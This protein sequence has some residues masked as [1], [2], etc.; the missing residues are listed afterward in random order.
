MWRFQLQALSEKKSF[1]L[2]LSTVSFI[3]HTLFLIIIF[4]SNRDHTVD[5]VKLNLHSAQV[6]F[7]PTFDTTKIAHSHKNHPKKTVQKKTSTS[8]LGSSKKT[9]G[10]AQLTGKTEHKKGI[11][12]TKVQE[13]S[14]TFLRKEQIHKQ[15]VS[16]KTSKNVQ[17]KETKSA[18]KVENT[19]DFLPEY[20]QKFSVA[21]MIPQFLQAFVSPKKDLSDKVNPEK[22]KSEKEKVKQSVVKKQ[23]EIVSAQLSQT[24]SVSSATENYNTSTEADSDGVEEVM[25]VSPREYNA[26]MV[27][28]DLQNALRLAW[29]P[30]PGVASHISAQVTIVV[31]R[32]GTVTSLT[33]KKPSGSLVYDTSIEHALHK[34]VLPESIWSKTLTITFSP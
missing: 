23:E 8:T 30:P 34:S 11:Q 12:K 21:G 18:Q 4:M 33:F 17:K 9:A 25:Y 31:D 24:N 7:V 13:V 29:T 5:V 2:R 32:K 20:N 16:K 1:L 26:L 27:H 3:L 6:R 10:V 28:Q 22:E 15:S 14:K 19:Y